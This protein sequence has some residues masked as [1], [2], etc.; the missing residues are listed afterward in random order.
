MSIAPTNGPQALSEFIRLTQSARY[1]NPSLSAAIAMKT[2][3]SAS[4]PAT[5]VK[6][7]AMGM[8]INSG[9]TNDKPIRY[10]RILGNQ[11]DAYA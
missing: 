1:R 10:T 5:A 7:P 3:K 9:Y 6:N 2:A 11:F 8:P 4:F